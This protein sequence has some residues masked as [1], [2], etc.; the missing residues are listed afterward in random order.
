MG[1]GVGE[2][3]Q[4]GY[5]GSSFES[6]GPSLVVSDPFNGE[7]GVASTDPV[8]FTVDSAAGL[9]EFSLDVDLDGLQAIVGGVFRPGYSGTITYGPETDVVVAITG[10]PP[11][12]GGPTSLDID[13]VDL[14]GNPANIVVNWT[15]VDNVVIPETVTLGEAV[16]TLMDFAPTVPELVTVGDTVA[17]SHGQSAAVSEILAIKEG[18][19]TGLFQVVVLDGETVKVLFAD[20]LEFTSTQ[21]LGNYFVEPD[22]LDSGPVNLVAV[23]QLHDTYQSGS[24]VYIV[25]LF[26]AIPPI[27]GSSPPFLGQEGLSSNILEFS[28]TGTF[29]SDNISEYIQIRNG[30]SADIYQIIDIYQP[31]Q[32][33]DLAFNPF[34]TRVL[35]D[36]PLVVKDVAAGYVEGLVEIISPSPNPILRLTHP[37]VVAGDPLVEVLMLE[38]RTQDISVTQPDLFD[39]TKID[40]LDHNTFQYNEVAFPVAT[41]DRVFLQAR[42]RP[43]LD[44]F[45]ISGVQ[46]MVFKTRLSPGTKFRA[47]AKYRFS[48]KNLFTRWPRQPF[49]V[50]AILFTVPAT[51]IVEQPRVR[52]VKYLN[53]AGMLVVT[54]DQPMRVDDENFANADDYVIS[55]PTTVAVKRAFSLNDT[56]VALELLGIGDGA[57]TLTV[58]SATPTDVAG[59]PLDPTFNTAIFVASIPLTNKSVFTDRGP[60]AKPPLTLQSGTNA[61]LDTFTDVA[62]PGAALTSSEVGMYLTLAGSTLNDGTYRISAVISGTQARLSNTAFALPDANSGS[63]TWTVFDPQ[64]GLIADDPGDVV[65]R[66]N[67]TPVTPLAVVGLLGQVILASAPLPTDDVKVDYSWCCNPNVE[68]R[69]LNSKEFRLNSWNRDRG[70]PHDPTQHKY[71]YNNTLIRPSDFEPLD[72]G[73]TLVQPE[74]RELH[75]RAFERAYTPVLNDPTLLL[76]NTPH[77]KIAYPPPSRRISEEFVAYEGIG[78]PEALTTDP[79]SRVGAGQASSASGVLT[80]QD[81][82]TGVFP[83]GEPVFW[84]R[85]IDLTFRHV[86]A[87][88]WRFSLDLVTTLEGVFTGIAAGY[89]DENIAVVVGFLDDGGTKKIGLLKLGSGDDPSA[90]SAWTG[91]I[92]VGDNPT[93]APVDFDWSVLHSYRLLRDLNGTI[94][95]FVDGDVVEILRATPDEMPLLEEVNAA[96]DTVQG[97]FFGSLSRPAETTSTWDFVRYLTLPT[98]PQQTLPSSFVAYEANVVPEQDPK[99]WT[100]VGFHGTESIISSDFLL[101]EATSATDEATADAVGDIGGDYKGFIRMEPLLTVASEVIYDADVQLVTQTHGV[102]PHG[103]MM[104]VDDGNRL[105]QLCFFPDR[106]TPKFSYGGR[107]LPEDFSPTAW[108]ALGGETA[109]MA[110]R[111]LRITDANVGD[112]KVYSIDDTEAV[113][114]TSASA[115]MSGLALFYQDGDTTTIDG[116]TYTFQNV[117]TDV[118]GNVQNTGA[119]AATLTNLFNAINLTGVPGVDYATSM[120][121]HTSVTATA[122]TAI[123]ITV[124][125]ITPGLLGN[126]ILV[127]NTIGGVDWDGPTLSGGSD[128]NTR[129]VSASLDYLLEARLKVVSY[130]VDGSGFAGAFAQVFDDTRSVGILLQ[131]DTSVKYVAFHADGVTG[132][133]ARFAFDW[134]DGAFHTYRISKSTSGNLVSLFID[135]AFVGSETYSSFAAPPPNPIGQ[136]SWGSTTPASSGSLSVV[137]WAY[138]NVWRLR[139]DLRHYVGLWRGSDDDSLLGYHLPLKTAGRGA[140]VS[141]NALGDGNADFVAASVATGDLLIVDAGPN[142]GVYEVAVV[143]NGQNLTLTTVLPSTPSLVDYRIAKETD[144]TTA[145]KYRIARDSTGTVSVL[146]DAETAPIIQVGYN[147][148]DLPSSGL[149]MVRTLSN[150]LPAMVF[151]SFDAENLAQSLW[152][153][154]RYGIIKSVTELRIVPHHEVLNQWNVMASPEHL[155]TSIAHDHTDFKSSSTGIP[156]KKDPDFMRDSGLTAYTLLNEDTPLVPSTQTFQVRRPFPIQETVSGLNRPEDVLNNDGDFTLNDGALRFRLIVPDDVLYSCLDVIEQTTG[157]EGLIHPF[158]DFQCGPDWG[159]IYY[160]DDVCLAYDGSVLPEVDPTASTPWELVSDAPAEVSASAF[161]G[162]LTYSTSGVGTRSV[163]RN[164]SPLPDAPSLETEARFIMKVLADSTLGT[165]DSQIRIGMSAPGLTVA[166]GFVTT[167]TAE[168]YVLVLD[169][170]SGAIVGSASFDYLDGAF[171]TYRIVRN[172][173]AGTVRVFIDS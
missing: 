57:Y 102:S 150:G 27:F 76:L 3:G 50:R 54:Y 12:P 19:T 162:I 148:I 152:D 93:S 40:F 140:T 160:Q 123:S 133:L 121:A 156:P 28:G 23:E 163:Y 113:V 96:F 36:R 16:A 18:V 88:S 135:G 84:T 79:W 22:S 75:Y 90:V 108:T 62:L 125:A 151:G 6:G 24:S 147:S 137:E 100:P 127:S 117:L 33:L 173:S 26:Y 136:I 11:F 166:L 95:I 138:V 99:P 17:T 44:W 142:R 2:Y 167:P 13:I 83:T 38:N 51:G 97:A 72:M 145:H 134:G 68:I 49:F 34:T 60:I 80:I 129:V 39:P 126:L 165:A 144:W 128:G 25:D 87:M 77:H 118:D 130:T 158:D 110:G 115:T 119:V 101:L 170:N 74:Q 69:R 153:Y 73:A 70:F 30:L 122:T 45:H 116:K 159:T 109:E 9:D 55:G 71:R 164:N 154:V 29:T 169:L 41:G 157:D 61:T 143:V 104:A 114:L 31:G 21:D 172:P 59:N 78:L 146:L 42:I 56:Q 20:E 120:T 53:D 32:G 132:A 43:K 7:T 86:F 58:S 1:Y 106:A 15:A 139:S 37:N 8:T 5:G 155:F 48:I 105:M 64:T 103:L 67:G 131:E 124:T 63:I 107:S 91:G 112:G 171:H 94:K 65:V 161:S 14:S 10:H 92:D 35:L 82:V 81:D 149:G 111:I 168:R 141:G 89:S 47:G 52:H 46:G 4:R 66:V 85:P 98:N